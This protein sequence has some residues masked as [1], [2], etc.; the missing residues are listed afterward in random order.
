MLF[1]ELSGQS[2]LNW[3]L[4]EGAFPANTCGLHGKLWDTAHWC[5][6]SAGLFLESV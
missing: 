2:I 5:H 3:K 4:G 1:Q 6:T